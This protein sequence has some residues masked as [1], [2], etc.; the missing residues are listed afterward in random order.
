I[1]SKRMAVFLFA[2]ILL[3]PLPAAITTDA[4]HAMRIYT[5]IP[6]PQI[7]AALGIIGLFIL[8]KNSLT[9]KLFFLLLSA[10]LIN[11]VIFFYQ[12][13]FTVF[14]KEQ[15]KSFQYALAKTIPFVLDNEPK[16][17]R[18]IFSNQDNLYQSYM[19]FLF[20]SAYDPSLYQKQ[21]GTISGGF[22]QSHNFGKYEFKPITWA[23]E[24]K[25][26]PTLF[27]GNPSDFPLD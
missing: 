23:L 4:P 17:N 9:Q 22:A 7:L 24:K 16:Y 27:V 3:A 26:N 2:W 20:F 8:L 14:P 6:A 10:A 19:F 13:Y 15:S 18:I 5:M 25:E 1:R 12:Q 21:G 11:S